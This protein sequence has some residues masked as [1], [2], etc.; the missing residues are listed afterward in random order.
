MTKKEVRAYLHAYCGI[1]LKEEDCTLENVLDLIPTDP[2]R[3]QIL[4]FAPNTPL[5]EHRFES[6]GTAN[7]LSG[8]L[9]IERNDCGYWVLDWSWD[10]VIG[11][12]PQG[13]DLMTAALYMCEFCLANRIPL[14]D[15]KSAKGEPKKENTKLA[16]FDAIERYEKVRFDM[17]DE[18]TYVS[19]SGEPNTPFIEMHLPSNDRYRL[20]A[21]CVD[22]N[23]M[24]D[25]VEY[26]YDKRWE[27]Y[28]Y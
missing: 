19:K 25:I 10:G 6:C 5:R 1:D 21:D 27:S 11:V 8:D 9:R 3:Q 7:I 23:R 14:N 26:F 2:Q 18:G 17:W 15:K 24:C 22:V 20:L 16:F 13:K 12:M 4:A 28:E